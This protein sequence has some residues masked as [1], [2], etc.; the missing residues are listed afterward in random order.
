[1]IEVNDIENVNHI[2]VYMTGEMPFPDGYSGAG[3]F[4]S[5]FSLLMLFFLFILIIYFAL[6]NIFDFIKKKV[7]FNYQIGGE[8]RL[9]YLG[10]LCNQKPSAIF[11]ISNLKHEANHVESTPFATNNGFGGGMTALAVPTLTSAMIGVSVEPIG[12]IDSLTPATETKATNVSSYV[13]FAQ[14]MLESFFNYASSFSQEA[15]N[16]QQYFPLNSL[17]TW[18]DNFK[19]RLEMNPNFW[20]NQ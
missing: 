17:H 13:E 9:I 4:S 12:Q 16:G 10:K 18:F 3:E 6:I 14:K 11:K 7:Y 5:F 20:K 15:P 1:M 2:V 19:R 8:S